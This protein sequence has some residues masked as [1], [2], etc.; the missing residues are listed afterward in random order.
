MPDIDPAEFRRVMGR[1]PTCVTVVTADSATGPSGMVIGSFVSVSLDPPLVAFFVGRSSR[2]WT[3]M[4]E[5]EQL[6]INVLAEDQSDVCSAFMRD[7]EERFDGIVWE[8]GSN[9]APEL[10][11]TAASLAIDVQS[12]QQAGDHDYVLGRITAMRDD[13]GFHPLVFH[14]GEF[15]TV[16]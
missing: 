16:R 12:I 6:V 15:R 1:I 7:A 4:Q 10:A 11:G 9:G 13:S 2:S 5:A 8:R 14:G 3:A